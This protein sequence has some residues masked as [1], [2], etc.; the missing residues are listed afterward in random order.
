MLVV[1]I[2]LAHVFA[3]AKRVFMVM[4]SAVQM[5]MN[6][7]LTMGDVTK[8]PTASTPSVHIIASAFLVIEA[9]ELGTSVAWTLMNVWS[10]TEDV[11]RRVSE[12][13]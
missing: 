1:T 5:I 13:L 6:V 9:T 11:M 10:T 7:K 3:P 12:R 2:T 4:A 8:W